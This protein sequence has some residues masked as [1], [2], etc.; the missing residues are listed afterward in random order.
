MIKYKNDHIWNER[1]CHLLPKEYELETNMLY[2]DCFEYTPD[3]HYDEI[4][5]FVT[6]SFV[7]RNRH[8][9]TDDRRTIAQVKMKWGI[10]TIYYEGGVDPYLDEVIATADRMAKSIKKKLDKMYGSGVWRHRTILCPNKDR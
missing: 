10:L 6:K 7:E 3:G 1:L 2:E 9:S 8:F 4:M 5:T